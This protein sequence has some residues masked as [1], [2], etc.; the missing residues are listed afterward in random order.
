MDN[1]IILGEWKHHKVVESKNSQFV[2]K[3][4]KNLVFNIDD[5]LSG[6]E[7][8]DQILWSY[9]PNTKIKHTKSGYIVKQERIHGPE[10]A[11]TE[12][13]TIDDTELVR[14]VEI[15]NIAIQSIVET[16]INVDLMWP[17]YKLSWKDLM[18]SNKLV[19]YLHII[20]Y[21]INIFNSLNLMTNKDWE[22]FYVDNVGAREKPWKI[23]KTIRIIFLHLYKTQILLSLYFRNMKN[24]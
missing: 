8:I 19:R 22:I 24:T 23:S 2:I 16:W 18:S 20:P 11:Q 1:R 3:L 10:L 14:L 13:R 7:Y 17:L 5:I 6:T 9:T 21:I 4:S 15:I 12:A